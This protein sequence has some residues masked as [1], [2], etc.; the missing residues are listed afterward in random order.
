MSRAHNCRLSAVLESAVDAPERMTVTVFTDRIVW[1]LTDP[2]P[3]EAWRL[4]VALVAAL[5]DGYTAF[6]P[7]HVTGRI[8]G[9]PFTCSTTA[10]HP[11]IRARRLEVVR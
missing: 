5:D 1:T 10:T 4:T 2:D 6:G 7:S 8:Q 3:S 11:A 9:V